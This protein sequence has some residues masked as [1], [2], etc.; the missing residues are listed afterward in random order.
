MT[1][2]SQQ[3]HPLYAIDRDQIDAVLG[4]QGEPG[5]QQLA[6]VGALLSRY[7]DFPG[8]E[9]IRD[10]LQK[11]YP[12]GLTLTTQCQDTAD[13]ATAGGLGRIRA[14]RALAQGQTWKMPKADLPIARRMSRCA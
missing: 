7:V 9:D 12:L 10:D 1:N 11:C 5:P 4:H 2:D 8:A 6:T 14:R 13:R 3:T